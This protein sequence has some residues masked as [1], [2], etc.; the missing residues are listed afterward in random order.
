[1]TQKVKQRAV[2]TSLTDA[3][4]LRELNRQLDWIFARLLEKKEEEEEEEDGNG[5]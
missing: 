2:L 1:M 3:R 4:Q 5:L